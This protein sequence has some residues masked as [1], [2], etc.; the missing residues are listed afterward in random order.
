M[1]FFRSTNQLIVSSPCDRYSTEQTP[2]TNKMRLKDLK[3]KCGVWVKVIKSKWS[4]VLTIHDADKCIIY[5]GIYLC[6]CT[7]M[8][9]ERQLTLFGYSHMFDLCYWLGDLYTY[10][11]MC[12]VYCMI[13]LKGHPVVSPDRPRQKTKLRV[14]VLFRLIALDQS[15]YSQLWSIVNCGNVLQCV[16]RQCSLEER[17]RMPT[18]LWGLWKGRHFGEEADGPH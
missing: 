12:W 13:H 6:S 9:Y 11:Y 10:A 15:E 14:K 2:L 4:G 5:N 1:I 3:R 16:R 17:A 18:R 7:N 8:N